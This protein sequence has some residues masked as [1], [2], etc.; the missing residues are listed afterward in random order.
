[1]ALIIIVLI[2]IIIFIVLKN[3]KIVSI[4]KPDEKIVT[5]P[6]IESDAIMVVKDVFNITGRGVVVVGKVLKDNIKIGDTVTI[7]NQE[8]M[9][10]I[11]STVIAIEMFR[12]HIEIANPGDYVG[13]FLSD[14]KKQDIE[15]GFNVI[16]KN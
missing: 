13:L 10:N 11:T 3:N 7:Q 6:N 8:N 14:V 1:M 16:K 12:K 9:N 5:D 4:T 2:V 15:N